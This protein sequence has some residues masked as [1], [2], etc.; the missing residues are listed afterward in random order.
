[1]LEFRRSTAA[2]NAMDMLTAFTVGYGQIQGRKRVEVCRGSRVSLSTRRPTKRVAV[3]RKRWRMGEQPSPSHQDRVP[4]P[5][6]RTSSVSGPK[7][8][9]QPQPSQEQTWYGLLAFVV[10]MVLFLGGLGI[11][12]ARSFF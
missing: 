12:I 10:I 5:Q 2:D 11:T 1:M 3:F 9:Q 4:A 7:R 6:Q 8:P